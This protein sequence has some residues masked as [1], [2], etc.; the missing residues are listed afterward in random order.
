MPFFVTNSFLILER[1]IFVYFFV[2]FSILFDFSQKFFSQISVLWFNRS[3][4][5]CE[6]FLHKVLDF[7]KTLGF[8][9]VSLYHFQHMPFFDNLIAI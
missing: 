3:C 8:S 7:F 4:R 9:V 5:H 6:S 1:S 2:F